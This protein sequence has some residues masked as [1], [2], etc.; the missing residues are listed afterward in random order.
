MEH[1]FKTSERAGC[2]AFM[3]KACR[4]HGKISQESCLLFSAET[5]PGYEEQPKPES[6]GP[7]SGLP[8]DLKDMQKGPQYNSKR[9]QKATAKANDGKSTEV[10]AAEPDVPDSLQHGPQG[11]SK[12]E[13]DEVPDSWQQ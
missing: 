1:G 11:S 9:A 13:K 3:R 5:Q 7:L 10:G 12:T 4:D 6:Q 8:D 2:T